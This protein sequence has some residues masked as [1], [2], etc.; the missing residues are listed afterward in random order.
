MPIVKQDGFST[1]A[2][3]AGERTGS[4]TGAVVTPI[5]ETSVF[6]FTST[7]QLI[8]AVSEKDSRDVYTRWSNPTITAAERKIA[9]LE[10][11]EDCAVF[12]SGMAAISTAII[13][14][15]SPGDHIVS[16]RDLYGG[17]VG[18]FSD[19]MS[20][21]GVRTTFIEATNVDEISSTV[22]SNTKILFLETPTNPTLKLVDLQKAADIAAKHGAKVLVDNTFA[23]PY[24][25]QPL[26]FNCHATLHSATKYL[27][28]HNDVTAGAIAGPRELIEP[29]K[30][31]RRT[32]G[33][34]L[35]PHGAWLMLRGMKTLALR[36]VQHNSNGQQIAEYLENHS[37]VE[38]VYYPGLST[39]PQHS[40][41]KRQM[42]GF[43]GVVSFELKGD[44]NQT[45]RFVDSLKLALLAPSL[46]GVETLVS[47]PSTASHYFMDPDERR[48]AGISDSL[49][50]LSLGIE[51]AEDI[52]SDL[53]Q[54]FEKANV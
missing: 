40:L 39:H 53:A 19:L 54:A 38:K 14:L 11:A 18:L 36:M 33:G 44:L 9:E 27:A 37:G 43:G 46:G 20:R 32:L 6:A 3:R 4:E 22:R 7:K 13:S 16:V 45:I 51:D 49:V 34:V 41:A 48:K 30:K 17:T 10:G 25:Q 31:L 1:K 28:G 35:D 15:V 21:F 2:V 5:Y 24:N 42:K 26:R 23:S 52:I 47:Q 8:D 29:M 50:R 12:S